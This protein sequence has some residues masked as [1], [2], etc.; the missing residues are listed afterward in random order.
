MSLW[1]SAIWLLT[2]YLDIY[3][4]SLF[5]LSGEVVGSWVLFAVLSSRNWLY[6]HVFDI[7][8]EPL[9]WNVSKWINDRE[10][11]EG[12]MHFFGIFGSSYVVPT[13]PAALTDVL[14]THAYDYSKPSAFKRYTTR[15]WGHGIISQEQDEHRT[16]RKTYLS[17]FNQSNVARLN[18]TLFAKSMQF[19]DRVSD[20]CE[21]S[22]IQDITGLKSAVIPIYELC[23]LV[24]LDVDGIF[25]LDFD[26]N[27][28][29]GENREIF[30]AHET[31]FSSTPQVRKLF[32]LYNIAPQWLLDIF[33]SSAAKKLDAAHDLLAG[34]CR[35]ILREHL[36]HPAKDDAKAVDFARNLVNKNLYNEDAAISQI[37][38]ILGAGYESTGGTLAWVFICLARNPQIQEQLRQELIEARK[39]PEPLG[40]DANYEKF[41]ML[42][43]V[44]MEATRL[45]PA[46]A[47]L[48]RKAIRD[49]SIASQFIPKG[50]FV[51]LSPHAHNYNKAVWG[52]KA[53]EFLPERWID[54]SDPLR[55][56][57]N[58]LGGAPATVCM[59][60]YF[61]GARSCVGRE[62]A[63]AQMKR[64]VALVVERFHLD[65]VGDPDPRPV[66]LFATT[67]P[68]DLK[69]HFTKLPC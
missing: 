9:A 16:H 8:D 46:F 6:D 32:L 10:Y 22:G 1:S 23:A 12:L 57:Q 27:T 7:F 68:H 3:A 2:R 62:L 30:E 13:S 66:G 69:L 5:L 21:E 67:P 33:P 51:A 18:S 39:G 40:A 45:Y 60:S 19:V 55:P 65:P 54:R 58:P 38:V 4:N 49:T 20:T 36:A 35:K 52:P 42:H 61:H 25:S 43:A 17:V 53:A 59:M 31:L 56:R 29:C 28:I 44:V 41:V 37:L 26:F 48:P 11:P 34:V 15:F 63:V 50:T 47:F 24:S 14:S 64:Q